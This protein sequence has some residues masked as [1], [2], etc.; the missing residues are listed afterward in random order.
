MSK[1]KKEKSRLA[2]WL[3]CAILVSILFLIAIVIINQIDQ[4]FDRRAT[5]TL[6]TGEGGI[7]CV[8]YRGAMGCLQVFTG[9]SI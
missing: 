6:V 1:E 5:P 9:P 7:K 4:F 8:H 3:N 2:N